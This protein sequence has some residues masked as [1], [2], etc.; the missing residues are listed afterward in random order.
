MLF[1]FILCNDSDFNESSEIF[2]DINRSLTMQQEI[3]DP[4]METVFNFTGL[5]VVFH[6]FGFFGVYFW[7]CGNSH[8]SVPGGSVW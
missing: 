6:L 1:I 8:G 5:V 7:S 3:N 4:N 2:L